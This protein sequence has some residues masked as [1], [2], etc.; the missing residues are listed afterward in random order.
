MILKNNFIILN[1]KMKIKFELLKYINRNIDL[2]GEIF[3]RYF[4]NYYL[5]SDISKLNLEKIRYFEYI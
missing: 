1:L 3:N 5:K 4:S 2:Y